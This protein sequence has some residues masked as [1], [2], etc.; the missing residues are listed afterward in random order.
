R[1]NVRNHCDALLKIPMR[2][3][4]SSLNASVAAGIALFEVVR[5]QTI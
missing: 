4:V 1:D 5:Q 3:E 2:G